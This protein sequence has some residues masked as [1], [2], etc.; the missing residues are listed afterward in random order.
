MELKID[1]SLGRIDAT[2]MTLTLEYESFKATGV[3]TLKMPDLVIEALDDHEVL[4][5]VRGRIARDHDARNRAASPPRHRRRR[6]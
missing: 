5:Q 6:T 3:M 2:W 1:K 4:L